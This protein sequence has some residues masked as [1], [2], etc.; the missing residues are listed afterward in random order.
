MKTIPAALAEHLKADATTTCHCWKV[1][2]KDG[3]VIGF[4]DH[5][6]A[7]SFAGT[8]YL[9]ASGFSA[10]D[11]EGETGLGAGVGEVAGGFSSEAIAEGDLAAGRFDGARVELFLVNWQA[12]DQHVLLNRREIGEVTRAGGAFRAELRSLAHRLGPRHADTLVVVQRDVGLEGV[13]GQGDCGGCHGVSSQAPSWPAWSVQPTAREQP[14]P[15]CRRSVTRTVRPARWAGHWP[16]TTAPPGAWPTHPW[17][18]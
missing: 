5:D 4:T 6:E 7:I 2:L 11:S 10:S 1:T 8:S 12:P 15:A 17:P 3:A 13:L 14:G 16:L 9:A 18:C